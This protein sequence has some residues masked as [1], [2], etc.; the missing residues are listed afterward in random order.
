[1]S[2]EYVTIQI[3]KDDAGVVCTLAVEGCQKEEF[4]EEGDIPFSGYGETATSALKSI[5]ED[6]GSTYLD[7]KF[8]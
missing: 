6:I 1:M 3:F 8:K 7:K 2:V 4:F 5:A